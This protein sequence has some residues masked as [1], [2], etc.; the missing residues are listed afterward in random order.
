MFNWPTDKQ[1]A[2]SHVRPEAASAI[3]GCFCFL[4]KDS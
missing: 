2:S 4:P 3:D 1:F